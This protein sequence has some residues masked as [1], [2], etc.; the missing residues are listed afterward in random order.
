MKILKSANLNKITESKLK[1]A[2]EKVLLFALD[3]DGTISDGIDFKQPQAFELIEKIFDRNKSVAII[4]ASAS[5]ALKKFVPSF[6]E[7][8]NKKNFKTRGFIAGANGA[9]LF[10]VKKKGLTE[11]YNYKMDLAQIQKVVEIG[12]SVY[13][14][15]GIKNT[16]LSDKGLETFKKF[17]KDDWQGYVPAEIIDVCRPYNGELFTEEAKVTF[18][19][20]KDKSIHEKLAKELNSELG[21]EY[22]AA[23]GDDTYIHITKRFEEDG[24]AMAMKK[25]LKLMDLKEDEVVTFGDMPRGNDAGLLSFPYSF[26]NS[27]EFI[28]IKENLDQP[29][30][31]LFE[32]NLTP[33]ARVYKTINY[34]LL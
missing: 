30:Y 34:L 8:F 9:T 28:S 20:P 25:I 22:C 11:I 31:I 5:T 23:I 3:Y 13:E 1:E 14:K 2:R 6:Q 26:T 29:P 27:E 33:V 24:K 4:T 19:L 16:D 21:N 10:E 18:V 17:L 12:K 32:P 7:L 15:L